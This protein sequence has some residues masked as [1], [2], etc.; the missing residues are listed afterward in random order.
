M[1]SRYAP[2]DGSHTSTSYFFAA[3][4]PRSPA[5]MFT[6]RYGS[7]S[8]PTIDSSIASSASCSSHD[9]AGS[10]YENISTLSN[11]CTRK[12]PRVSLP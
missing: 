5:A 8:P 7:P 6:T 4:A 12:M 9:V 1:S 11:W 10:A 3:A 2:S